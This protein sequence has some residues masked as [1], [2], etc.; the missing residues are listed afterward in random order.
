MRQ[1]DSEDE[2]VSNLLPAYVLGLLDDDEIADVEAELAVSP[3][4][5]SEHASLLGAADA[6]PHTIPQFDPPAH[7]RSRIS[8]T[9]APE[10]VRSA[11][12]ARRNWWKPLTSAAAIL[13]LVLAGAV[14]V[15]ASQ[16][17]E[18]EE[19]LSD[20]QAAMARPGTDFTQPLVWS[21]I[22]ESAAGSPVRGYFCRTEDGSVGWIIVEG[23]HTDANHVFQ[24][25]LVDGDRVV[26]GGM[27]ATDEDGRGFGVVRVG[28]PVHTFSQIWITIEPPG[29]SPLPS[30]EPDLT[31]RIV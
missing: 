15:L 3:A 16:L 7:L 19:E 31:A 18:R 1:P 22:N 27:F 5:R 8:S 29:G 24:L 12:T 2:D 28:V 9:V 26:D 17:N 4:L 11:S 20:L 30:R 10:S 25:W 6:L 13:V 14:A 23:M 21:P